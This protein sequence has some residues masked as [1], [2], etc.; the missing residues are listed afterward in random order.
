MVAVAVAE[1][2]GEVEVEEDEVV[3]GVVMGT[4]IKVPQF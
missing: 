1:D 2:V 4:I 3:E